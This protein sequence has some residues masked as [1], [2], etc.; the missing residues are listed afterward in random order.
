[1]ILIKSYISQVF[2]VWTLDFI[3]HNTGSSIGYIFKI[4]ICRL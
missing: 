4:R 3:E 1:M 2:F